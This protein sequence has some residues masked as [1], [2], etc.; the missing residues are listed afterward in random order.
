MAYE[1]TGGLP[2]TGYLPY[3]GTGAVNGEPVNRS[4]AGYKNK[5]GFISASDSNNTGLIAT[6]GIVV[7]QLPSNDPAAF[8]IGCPAGYIPIGIIQADNGV[9]GNEPAK[10]TYVFQDIPVDIGYEGTYRYQVM[11]ATQTGAL[12]LPTLD[13]QLIF[14][15]TSAGIGAAAIGTVEAIPSSS[16]VPVGWQSFPGYIVE[17]TT[18]NGVAIEFNFATN[19][20]ANTSNQFTITGVLTSAAAATAITI[21]PDSVVLGGRKVYVTNVLA[22]VGGATAWATTATVVLQ[23]SAAVAGVTY[24]VAGLTANATLGLTTANVTLAAPVS[25]NAGFTASKGLQIV[26]NANG[27]GS[28]LFVTVTGYIR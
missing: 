28:N 7:S 5:G 14:R 18:Q 2:F 27:T 11:S 17:S 16:Q 6:F 10:A 25:Q 12:A 22:N 13:Y 23:D 19:V 8:T 15:A 21:I 3:K 24:A 26:G 4:N 20:N 1:Y 9:L